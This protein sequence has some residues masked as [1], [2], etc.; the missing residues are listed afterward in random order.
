[1]IYLPLPLP[2]PLSV[3]SAGEVKVATL[4]QGRKLVGL[5]HLVGVRVQNPHG[6]PSYFGRR[7]YP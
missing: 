3:P 5:L 7:R 2:L 1:M 4:G 6:Y